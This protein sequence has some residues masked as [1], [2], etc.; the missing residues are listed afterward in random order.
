[1][2]EL[3]VLRIVTFTDNSLQ[4]IIIS[5]SKLYNGLIKKRLTS[6]SNNI[7]RFEMP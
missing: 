3:L 4:L 1:M 5:Y 6:R 2:Y 7:T